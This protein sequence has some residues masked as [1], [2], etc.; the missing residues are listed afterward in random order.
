MR[1]IFRIILVLMIGYYITAWWLNQQQQQPES[2]S[3]KPS[4]QPVKRT[5]PSTPRTPPDPLTDIDGIGPAFERALNA[6][7]IKTFKDL[8]GQDPDELADKLT[9]V[10]ITAARIK[11][12]RWIEQAAER[13]TQTAVSSRWSA[14]D[15]KSS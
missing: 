3:S 5:P 9:G 13:A 14:N 12:D 4:P 11:K 1:R 8:A 10:R 2:A 15:G 6:I 7:G